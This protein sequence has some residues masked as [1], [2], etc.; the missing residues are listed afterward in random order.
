MCDFYVSECVLF[1]VCIFAFSN[2]DLGCFVA[3]SLSL[4]YHFYFHFG[5]FTFS[6]FL[7]LHRHRAFSTNF[8]TYLRCAARHHFSFIHTFSS[9]HSFDLS[10]RARHSFS[11]NRYFLFFLL[12]PFRFVCVSS[13]F[14]NCC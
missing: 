5:L 6:V 1:L 4:F 2:I 11:V 10:G 12:L 9:L 7:S 13:D 3:S 8:S 14:R